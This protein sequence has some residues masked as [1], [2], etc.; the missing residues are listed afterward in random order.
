MVTEKEKCRK[1]QA[2]T[3]TAQPPRERITQIQYQ[4]HRQPTHIEEWA[5][6]YLQEQ[7]QHAR[8]PGTSH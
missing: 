8:T 1:C 5:L 6:H 3:T 2:G 7:A 4:I